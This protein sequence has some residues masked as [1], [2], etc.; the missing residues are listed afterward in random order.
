MLLPFVGFECNTFVHK[1]GVKSPHSEC[2]SI[3]EVMW[4]ASILLCLAIFPLQANET[5][6]ESAVD[7]SCLRIQLLHSINQQI[8]VMVIDV[9]FSK[10]QAVLLYT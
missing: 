3:L 8:M 7:S 9:Y 4:L 2:Y 1:R 6:H 5:L 10:A